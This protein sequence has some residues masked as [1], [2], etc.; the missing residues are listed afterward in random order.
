MHFKI[1][2]YGLTESMNV[3]VCAGILMATLNQRML[4]KGRKHYGL[5]EEE[6]QELRRNFYERSARGVE[7][8]S[9][10]TFIE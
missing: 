2:Q 4:Q 10:V 3:S 5:S 6:K 1:P 7:W 8:N 9:P